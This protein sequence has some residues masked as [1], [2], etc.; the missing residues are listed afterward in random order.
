MDDY[1]RD[2]ANHRIPRDANGNMVFEPAYGVLNGRMVFTP[3]EGNWTADLWATN[4]TDEQYING[5][6]DTRTVWGFN[7]S[8]IGQPR[9]VGASL[10]IRF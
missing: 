3:S 5:G 7:F 10:N 1:V 9:E 8:V 4:L 6:F 2:T